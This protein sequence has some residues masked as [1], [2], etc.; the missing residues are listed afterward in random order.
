MIGFIVMITS[1]KLSMKFSKY[2]NRQISDYWNLRLQPSPWAFA[3]W[4]V[5]Y[6]LMFTFTV[7]Q[8]LPDSMVDRHNSLIFGQIKHTFWVSCLLNAGWLF[9]FQQNTFSGFLISTFVIILMWLST[10]K[11]MHLSTTHHLNVVEIISM[12]IGFSLYCG[13]LTIATVLNTLL[14]FES[15]KKH[16]NGI[17]DDSYQKYSE[18]EESIS[19][20]IS[21]IALYFALAIYMLVVT[22]MKNPVYGLAFLWA[23]R[24]IQARQKQYTQFIKQIEIV[25]RIFRIYM[26]SFWGYLIYEKVHGSITNG[27]LY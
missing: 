21:T 25:R 7:Y 2:T 15:S 11:M 12:R 24:A 14:A 26:L 27:I 4:A 18:S 20:T 10:F 13:W 6:A 9:I 22:A 5:I 19:S 3:I 17:D 23:L 1:N 16:F 8:S